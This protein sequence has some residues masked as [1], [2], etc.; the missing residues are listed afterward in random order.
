MIGDSNIYREMR[1]EQLKKQKEMVRKQLY[2]YKQQMHYINGLPRD[3]C[4]Y[5]DFSNN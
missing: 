4:C 2:I 1:E 3:D 5:I